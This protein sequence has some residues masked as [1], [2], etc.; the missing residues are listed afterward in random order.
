[1]LYD[2]FCI[3]KTVG[4]NTNKILKDQM[5]KWEYCLIVNSILR[6]VCDALSGFEPLNV[7]TQEC[8]PDNC[9]QRGNRLGF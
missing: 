7:C 2:I 4:F 9:C 3:L 6:W 8:E 1:M 5:V